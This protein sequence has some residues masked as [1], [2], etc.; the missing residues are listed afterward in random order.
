MLLNLLNTLF[1]EL[2]NPS[3]GVPVEKGGVSAPVEQ[4]QPDTG[5]DEAKRQ[6]VAEILTIDQNAKYTF[7]NEEVSGLEIQQW[8]ALGKLDRSE[9]V[10]ADRDNLRNEAESRAV[11]VAK[12]QTQNEM[13]QKQIDQLNQTEPE[14]SDLSQVFDQ[15]TSV[16]TIPQQQEEYETNGQQQVVDRGLVTIEQLKTIMQA[17][18]SD[19][20]RML[21]DKFDT[22]PS[23]DDLTQTQQ[24]AT[25]EAVAQV[26]QVQDV[27]QQREASR[28]AKMQPLIQQMVDERGWTEAEANNFSLLCEQ[29]TQVMNDALQEDDDGKYALS[30]EL[31]AK[32]RVVEKQLDDDATARSTQEEADAAMTQTASPRQFTYEPPAEG[33]KPQYV[34]SEQRYEDANAAAHEILKKGKVLG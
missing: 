11:E 9:S 23:R 12:L 31:L 25:Q 20:Q 28:T 6:S 17:Q 15:L 33:E 30:Q 1:G 7:G 2:P 16:P 34:S 21:D 29:Y 14:P 27:R 26:Q 13:Y 10:Q 4:Q 3:S 19:N 8:A 5:A 32:S 22:I 18:A 24:L